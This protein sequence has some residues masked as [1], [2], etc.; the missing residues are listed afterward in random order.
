M[1][2]FVRVVLLASA[3]LAPAVMA[4]E[5]F[6]DPRC[7]TGGGFCRVPM[8]ALLAVPDRYDEREVVVTGIA[9][10][11]S[12]YLRVYA[13]REAWEI[14]DRANSLVLDLGEVKRFVADPA[15]LHGKSVTVSGT[16]EFQGVDIHAQGL[17]GIAHV[18]G[19]Q[20]RLGQAELL[21]LRKQRKQHP[22][23]RSTPGQ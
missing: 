8:E 6:D 1:N 10:V 11:D 14:E 18:T 13:S 19:V 15:T 2:R 21:E 16:F 4:A 3:L 20:L 23:G 17:G 9:A 5:A 12:E 22:S 7:D